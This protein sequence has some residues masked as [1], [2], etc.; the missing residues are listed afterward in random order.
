MKYLGLFG[1]QD[2]ISLPFQLPV[3]VTNF[4]TYTFSLFLMVVRLVIAFAKRM[5]CECFIVTLFLYVNF[6]FKQ[7]NLILEN[8][9]NKT[10]ELPEDKKILNI[11]VKIHQEVQ[12]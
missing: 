11:W 4:F 2:T 10:Y 12:R 5:V 3:D 7:L 9:L 8:I 1:Y 6:Y